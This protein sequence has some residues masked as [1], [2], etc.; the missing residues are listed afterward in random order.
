MMM[1][2]RR[3]EGVVAR[4]VAGAHLL[5]PV[6]E[7]A[8]SVYTLNPVGHLLWELVGEPRSAG[9]LAD[10]LVDGYRVPRETALRDV[11][12][13]LVDLIRLGLIESVAEEVAVACACK[14]G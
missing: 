11:D 2:Y 3:K 12:A 1:K 9:E 14:R 10:R 6:Q 5:I 8:R 7:S 13:F 4:S